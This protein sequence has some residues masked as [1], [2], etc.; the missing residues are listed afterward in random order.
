MPIASCAPGTRYR[1]NAGSWTRLFEKIIKEAFSE[2]RKP[3]THLHGFGEPLLA[4]LLPDGI[5]LAK[6][7]ESRVL[8]SRNTEREHSLHARTDGR[9]GAESRAA[10]AHRCPVPATVRAPE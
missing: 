4:K 6:N 8:I 10:A 9:R 5:L 7:T 1:E 3:V 2:S